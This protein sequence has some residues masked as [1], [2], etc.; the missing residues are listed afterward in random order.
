MLLA[1]LARAQGDDEL[2][3]DLLRHM[4]GGHE[5]AAIIAS[6]HL[7]AQL[8][9]AAEHAEQRRHALNYD[10]STPPGP[11]GTRMAAVAVSVELTRRGW[12]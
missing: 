10:P 3:R 12:D 11:L 4:G 5:P 2:A 7:A 6:R 9:M 8:G 1:A